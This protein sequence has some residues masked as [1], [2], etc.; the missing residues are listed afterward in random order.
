MNPSTPAA[1]AHHEQAQESVQD[2]IVIGNAYLRALAA[3]DFDALQALFAPE[4]RF[5]AM[6]PKG[7]RVGQTAQEATGWVRRWF[8]SCDVLQV[9]RSDTRMLCGRLCVS[10]HLRVHD[11]QDGWQEI[12]QHVYSVARDGQIAD[13]WLVCSGFLNIPAPQGETSVPAR[14]SG[15]DAF[16]DAGT[17]GCSEGPMDDI[18]RIVRQLTP[19]QTL[20][21]HASDPSVGRDLP[22][23]CRMS[24][25]TIKE[26]GEE[27]Y[28]IRKG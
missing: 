25:N 26:L 12:E 24:G 3:Q 9:L 18:A 22:A 14:Q 28:L 4:I 27:K 2:A 21:V 10:Y 7:E 1:Q 19:G 17:R 8:G 20:E 13:L 16:Y 15:S 23:W 5:R 6:V 11:N